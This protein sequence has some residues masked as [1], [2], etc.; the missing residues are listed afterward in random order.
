MGLRFRTI[1]TAK[2]HVGFVASRRGLRRVYLPYRNLES[3]RRAIRKDVPE[4]IEDSS[5]M[6]D[7]ARDLKRYFAGEAVKFAVPLDSTGFTPFE[8]DVWHACRRIG[9]GQTRSYKH[10]AEYMGR[11]GG[12]RAIGMAMRRNPWPIVV[13]CHRVVKSDGSLGGFSAPGGVALKQRL[14]EME[15]ALLP[16]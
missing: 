5:L 12:A 8:V 11:P 16:V 9:Y 3:L 4:A 1:E 10:L 6:P 13:P 15:A 7:L 2:G 14:L